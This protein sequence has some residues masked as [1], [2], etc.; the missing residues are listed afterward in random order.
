MYTDQYRS[1][2]QTYTVTSSTDKHY[3]LDSE[4]DFRSGFRNVGHQQQV[5]LELH[6]P[7]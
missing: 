3:S 5:F 2:D 7:G 1:M 6:S 4:D